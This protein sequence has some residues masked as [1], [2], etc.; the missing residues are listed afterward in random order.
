IPASQHELTDHFLAKDETLKILGLSWLP[1]EDAFS[2]VIASTATPF[3]TRRSILSFVA[4]LYDLLGWAA[5]V[6]MH[7]REDPASRAL[8]TQERLGYAN[9][10]GTG[11]ALEGLCGRSPAFSTNSGA[12]LDR[13]AKREL[14][15]S[16][17][18][19]K[20]K[21]APVKTISIP[22][23]ELNAVVLLSHLLVWT[24]QAL[25]LSNVPTYG[26]TDSTITLVWLQQHPSKWTTYVANRVSEVQ[27]ALSGATWHH[28]PSKE[29]PADCAS[30]GLLASLLLPHDLWWHGP[31][32]LRRSST[33]W[34][35]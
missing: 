16:L 5:P 26:W 33:M 25:A 32:W 21:V 14:L 24:Q 34:P 28:V 19:A 30:R 20:T 17:I 8:A 6:V 1:Q 29:N 4:K 7:H 11:A 35:K 10:T 3:P 23:L 12:S 31:A 27:T 9:P 2:F 15:V 22:R 13:P 18:C